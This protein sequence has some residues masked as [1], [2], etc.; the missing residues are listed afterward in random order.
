MRSDQT[1]NCW[2]LFL[3]SKYMRGKALACHVLSD[4]YN[5]RTFTEGLASTADLPLLDVSAALSNDGRI[6]I[7][8]VNISDTQSMSTKLPVTTGS[9]SVFLVGGSEYNIRTSNK[10]DLETVS[11]KNLL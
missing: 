4:A 8:V 6:N 10:E 7:A 9:V 1:D 11:I 3:F 5:G 2:P